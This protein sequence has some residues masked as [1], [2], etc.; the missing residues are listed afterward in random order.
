MPT[1]LPRVLAG[2][3]VR[4][5]EA[6]SCSFWIALS[7]SAQVRVSIWMGTRMA[8]DSPGTVAGG[9][10]SVAQSEAVALRKFGDH[11]YIGV[12]TVAL[13]RDGRP[14]LTPGLIYSYDLT[15]SGSFGES[16]LRQEGLLRDEPSDPRIAGVDRAAPRQ[17]ALGYIENR[18]PSFVA[19]PGAL[20]QLRLAHASCRKTNG[21]G[22]DAMAWLD[23]ALAE[24]YSDPQR[25][26]QQLFLTGDQIYADDVAACLLPMLNGLGREVMGDARQEQ[27]PI[28]SQRFDGTIANFPALRRAKLV[29]EQ[30]SLSSGSSSSHLL[31][32]AEF[33]AMYLVAWSPRVW[34]SLA[35]NDNLFTA[36]TAEPA[37]RAVLTDWEACHQSAPDPAQAWR[38]ALEPGVDRDRT[39]VE[40]YRDG[41]P[42]VARALA[43]VA[44]Y[45]IFDD[46]EVT[47]DWNLNKRWRNRVY[48]R[49]V[50]KA[51]VRNG[52]MAYGLFQ[53][54]GNDPA[55][56]AKADST[57]Q[58][59]L[60]EVQK[61][62]GTEPAAAGPLPVGS[63]DRLDEL[64]GSTEAG[65]D[66]RVKW[67]YQVAGP[68]HLVVVLDTRTRR[69]F[70]G[71]GISP[72]S[73]LGDTLNAQVPD[74][75][76]TDGR[77]LLVLVSAAPVLGPHL[78]D[79]IAAP[80]YETIADVKFGLNKAARRA[81]DPCHPGGPETGVESADAE[82]WSGQETAR[83]ELLKRL[84]K[85]GR[86]VILSG[87]VH[88][89]DTLVLDH[90]TGPS[91]TAAR[92]VQLTSSPARNSFSASVEALLRSNALLQRYQQG[93][94]PE[95]LAWPKAAPIQLPSGAKIG[96]GRRARMRRSPALVPSRDWPTGTTI[97][98]DQQPAWRWRLQLVRDDRPASQLPIDAPRPPMLGGGDLNAADRST[99]VAVYRAIAVRHQ[100]AAQTDNFLPLRQMV[101]TTNLGLVDVLMSEGALTVQHTLLSR[102]NTEPYKGIPNTVHRVSLSATA[103]PAPTLQVGG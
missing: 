36:P 17:L 49:P 70:R 94:A 60:A 50:G 14:P 9:E 5:V 72:P 13:G 16:G 71:E 85:H 37:L 28:A 44:T 8:G 56:F 20:D 73:L 76:M 81:D 66:K 68:R 6:T 87:D 3:I 80:L 15:L 4:R 48:S 2:P 22:P 96:P 54:W 82:G 53:G 89:G 30:G 7:E 21:S 84:A 47:D 99:H 10:G 38:R 35:T 67:F 24:H 41:V 95:L 91:T 61:V 55:E 46:H 74:G 92:I 57:N 52:V 62:L 32:F 59:F 64:V 27:I 25:R 65:N 77:E 100:M 75:P 23:D 103:A 88:Y 79:Q 97:P 40:T 1:N 39:A 12:V 29:R 58:K 33:V 51:I 18:L 45:M 93:L 83:E 101:F 90:W 63:T 11:L 19:P 31:T 102:T 43:N 98:A 34:R 86:A 26:V 69:Q 42:K 78:I